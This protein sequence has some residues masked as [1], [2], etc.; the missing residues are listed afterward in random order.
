[1]EKEKKLSDSEVINS[2]DTTRSEKIVLN[3]FREMLKK[4]IRCFRKPKTKKANSV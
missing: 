3:C 1:M 2:T 4:C